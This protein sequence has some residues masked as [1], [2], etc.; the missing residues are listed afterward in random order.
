ME[1]WENWIEFLDQLT[2]IRFSK[3]NIR[4]CYLNYDQ[5]TKTYGYPC[6]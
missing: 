3:K 1:V 4:L 2:R 5:K 6:Y